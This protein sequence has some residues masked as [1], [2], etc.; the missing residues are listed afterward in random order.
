VAGSCE[1]G[2]DQLGDC[3]S[4]EKGFLHGV[5]LTFFCQGNLTCNSIMIN[6]NEKGNRLS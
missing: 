4:Q 3:K 2:F 5:S 6:Y 1:H